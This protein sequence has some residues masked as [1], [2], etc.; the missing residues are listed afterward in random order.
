MSAITI[1]VAVAVDTDGWERVFSSGFMIECRP[2]PRL[3]S[4]HLCPQAGKRFRLRKKRFEPTACGKRA[5]LRQIGKQHWN[6][7][8]ACGVWFRNPRSIA[9]HWITSC[10]KG[11]AGAGV[12]QIAT[13]SN[14]INSQAPSAG[15]LSLRLSEV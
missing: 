12:Q 3:S 9:L 10:G 8:L 7:I 2:K 1:A 15:T 14:A 4:S 11:R 5:R 13:K 6:H